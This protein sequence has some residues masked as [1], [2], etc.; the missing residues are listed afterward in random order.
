MTVRPVLALYAYRGQSRT[1]CLRDPQRTHVPRERRRS[2]S[3][4]E[5]ERAREGDED[6]GVGCGVIVL[7][8]LIT[9]MSIESLEGR[10]LMLCF[11]PEASECW[12]GTAD[13]LTSC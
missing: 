4:G 10:W 3:A 12:K 11:A 13:L 1:Q 2:R 6:V 8:V 7:I 5:V 9:P